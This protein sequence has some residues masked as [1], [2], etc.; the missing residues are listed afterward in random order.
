MEATAGAPEREHGLDALRVFA[1]AILIVYHSCL[2]YVSWPWIVNDSATA[3]ALE[4]FLVA[5]NRWRLPLLFFVSG[6][7]AAFS[8]RRRS[9][10]AFAAERGTRLG[11][12]LAVGTFLVC[13]PQTY[14]GQRAHGDPISYLELYC[15]M[16]LPAPA[17]TMTWIHLWF[18]AYVLVFSIAGLP[19]LL[20][21]RSAAGARAIDA[22]VRRCGRWPPALYLMVVP[23]A[24]VIALLGPRWPT[25][26]NLVADWANLC[27]GLVFFLWGFAVASS[28]AWLDLVTARRWELLA[29]GGGAAALFFLARGTGVTSSWPPSVQLVFWGAVNAVYAVTW[30]L[31]LV[32][33]ARVLFTRPAAWLRAANQAVY[34][35]YI[36]HQTV[37]VAAVYVL[38]PW[39]ASAWVKLPVVTAATFLGSWAGYEVIRRVRWLRPLFGLRPAARA[40]DALGRASASS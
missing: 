5:V 12:P 27:G 22:A 24:L 25:T 8:L 21:I 18:V 13:P 14:L 40:R 30:V 4:P 31:A 29:A 1:F 32:G 19:L 7:A 20:A 38:L 15:S 10:G 6:A 17:G 37:T 9:P 36:L 16:Y 35:F 3:R 23:S 11:L 34:P 2:A 26:Y 28:R 33:H 39:A